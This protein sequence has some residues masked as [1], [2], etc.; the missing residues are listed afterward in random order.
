L[1]YLEQAAEQRCGRLIWA[2][3]DPTYDLVRADPRF[4]ALRSRMNLP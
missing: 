3:V 1:T 4:A 2:I